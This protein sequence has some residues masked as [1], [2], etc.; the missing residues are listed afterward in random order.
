MIVKGLGRAFRL[1]PYLIV[2][3]IGVPMV[4][5]ASIETGKYLGLRKVPVPV[6]GTGSM[7]PSL[8]WSKDEGGPE[9]E[10]KKVVEEYRTTP[11]LYPRYDGLKIGS[12]TIFRRSLGFGDM[13][14]FKNIKTDEILKAD[15]RENSGGF[16]KR[17]I[18]V[19]GDT[20]E[21]RD[22]YVYK[23]G[24]VFSEPYITSPRSSYGGTGL[25][26][27]VKINIPEGSYF[28]LGDNRKVSSDSR[29]ELG[30]ISEKDIEYVLPYAEQKIYQSLW[31]DTSKDSDLMGLP[32]LSVDEFVQLVNEE[33]TSK[34]IKKLSI[35]NPLI[36]SSAL[37]GERLLQD[38]NT[39]YNMKA[40][41]TAAGY[42]NI[43]MGEFVSYGHFTAKELLENLLYHPGTTKQILNRDFSDLGLS[44]IN[45]DID[46]CPS[47][48]IVGHLGGY[49]PADYDAAVVSS[50]RALRDNLRSIIPTWEKAVDYNNIDQAKLKTLLTVFRKRLSL[51][52]EI[53]NTMEKREW[54]TDA[55]QTRIKNDDA[56]SKI[57]ED[58]ANELNKQ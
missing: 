31:R 46:G 29:F 14:A 34:G 43:V 35:K 55:Q 33:R 57:T 17:I 5:M 12:Y 54:L 2:T 18:G 51:A 23:N 11:H 30:L 38:A 41:V 36:R 56:D 16:I 24:A 26:D 47:Q 13:V 45:R 28:V 3:L 53:V 58:L 40:S 32:T 44:D 4:G 20:I 15:E 22:G 52:E 19:P 6:V 1:L 39:P 7:Y 8:F 9:D 48:I 37:R 50:W 21:L 27:C 25:K 42:S 49:I 10:T